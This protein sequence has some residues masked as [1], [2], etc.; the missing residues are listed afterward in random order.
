MNR[1]L[2]STAD[3]GDVPM[4][5][6]RY[7]YY[8]YLGLKQVDARLLEGRLPPAIFYNLLISARAPQESRPCA[9]GGTPLASRHDSKH[10]FSTAQ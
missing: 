8:G 4:P 7:A 2:E 10:R 5:W 9:D 6:I 1:T 3:P